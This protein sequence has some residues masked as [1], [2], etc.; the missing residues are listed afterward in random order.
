MKK[1]LKILLSI[2]LI[3]SFTTFAYADR[4][5]YQ[6]LNQRIAILYK[7]ARFTEAIEVGKEVIK[8]AEE[9][10]GADHAFVI[11]SINNL[12]LIYFQNG[13]YKN[14]KLTYESA[15]SKT[16]GLVG[17]NHPNLIK[18]L[19]DIQKCCKKLGETAEID[20]INKRLETLRR[21]TSG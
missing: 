6:K 15:L 3:S 1:L 21:S 2:I 5:E 16:E 9:T 14:A 20:D 4:A 13:D 19:E 11:S 10:Y 12:A 7:S 18:I 8:V 17:T